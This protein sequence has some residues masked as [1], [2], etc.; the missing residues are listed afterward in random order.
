MSPIANGPLSAIFQA[1][2]RPDM[3]GRVMSLISSIAS[4][5]SPLGLL[6]A[7][8]LAEL[9]GVRAWYII[10]GSLCMLSAVAAFAMP[11]IMGIENNPAAKHRDDPSPP[12]G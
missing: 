12:A 6:A 3:L 9:L 2:V 5:M 11:S 7:A 10:G 8:P 1:A 4:A